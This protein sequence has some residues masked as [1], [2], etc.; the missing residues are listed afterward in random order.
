[1]DQLN[2]T[3]APEVETVYVMASPDVSFV[4]SSGVTEIAAFGGDVSGLVP[5]QV[6]RGYHELFPDALSRAPENPKSR[7]HPLR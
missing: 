4:S 7:T 5:G 2:R 6:A 3:L 1:M